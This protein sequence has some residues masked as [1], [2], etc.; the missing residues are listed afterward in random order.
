MEMFGK[1]LEALDRDGKLCYLLGMITRKISLL[2]LG[3]GLCCLFLTGCQTSRHEA[4]GASS[5]AGVAYH[6]TSS[7]VLN[8][9]G[10]A[11]DDYRNV[12]AYPGR[13]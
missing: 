7:D 4:G 13:F 9:Q 10:T 6:S 11:A 1:R 2:T 5:Q 12:L 3:F 8:G